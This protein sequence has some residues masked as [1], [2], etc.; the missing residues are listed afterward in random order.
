MGSLSAGLT[1]TSNDIKSNYM[2]L[3]V[4][5]LQNQNPL[6]PMSSDEM[7]AQLAQ[8]SQLE[9]LENLDSTFQQALYTAEVS[10][11]AALIDKQVAYLSENGTETVTG[12]VDGISMIDGK[13]IVSVGTQGVGLDQILAVK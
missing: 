10:Q 5:Q 12:K 1:G 7:T 6:E 9:H 2:T 8:L 4:T 11:G 13:V 3:L